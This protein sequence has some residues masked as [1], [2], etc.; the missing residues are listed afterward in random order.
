MK[1]YSTAQ[2]RAQ[3]ASL[4]D[5]VEGGETVVIERRGVRFTLRAEETKPRR[6]SRA[7]SLIA[8]VDPAVLSGNW[9]WTWDERGVRFARRGRAG[10]R[11]KRR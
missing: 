11:R 9:T 7:D 5:A 1:R 8:R 10:G 4:L 6:T 2:A 3:L